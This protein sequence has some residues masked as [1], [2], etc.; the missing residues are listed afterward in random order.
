MH[1]LAWILLLVSACTADTGDEG[2]SIIHNLAPGANCALTPG[3]AFLSRGT[4]DVKSPNPYLLTPEF[5]SRITAGEGSEAQRTIALRG[6]RIEVTNATSPDQTIANNKFTSLFAA[7]LSPLGMTTAS[8]DVLTPEI[9]AQLGVTPTKRV[10][11]VA[12][13]T[14]FGALG[15]SGDEIDGVPFDIRSPSVM[16]A[17]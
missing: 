1:R 17:S 13:V 2:F 4:I 14:P 16:A 7:S 15:G 10:Q 11:V 5:T 9:I 8:L 12:K 3:G 6:A